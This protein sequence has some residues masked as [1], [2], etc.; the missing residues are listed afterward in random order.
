M[1]CFGS[2]KAPKDYRDSGISIDDLT[3]VVKTWIKSHENADAFAASLIARAGF[4]N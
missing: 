4:P 3:T 2:V 1:A